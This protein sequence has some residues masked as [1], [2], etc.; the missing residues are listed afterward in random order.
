M[1]GFL[2][3]FI[4]LTT[5]KT[6]DRLPNL[7]PEW[8]SYADSLSKHENRPQ[9]TPYNIGHPKAKYSLF[10]FDP[11]HL[12][13]DSFCLLGFSQK[14]AQVIDRYRKA[15]G[16]F[17][18]ANDFSRLY[19][20]NDRH[21]VQ[22]KPFIR[23]SGTSKALA[24]TRRNS[25]VSSDPEISQASQTEFSGKVRLD[26]RDSLRLVYQLFQCELNSVDSTQL[27]LLPGVGPYTAHKILSYRKRL[28]GFVRVDQLL[29]AGLDH[30]L[31]ERFGDKV[32]VD[33]RLVKK[34]RLDSLHWAFLRSHPYVGTYLTRGFQ[35]YIRFHSYPRSWSELIDNQ[36]ITIEKVEKLK[37]YIDIP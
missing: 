13:V 1:I 36:I 20:V 18:D 10:I 16:F 19:V 25:V 34:V 17:R 11:N 8:M 30:A 27:L 22:L 29:E 26:K 37:Y 15:G 4:L 3:L 12:S 35:L 33:P 2:V 21:F 24:D 9:K 31:L 32:K 5:L 6:C 23:I 28:G 14:Q 7:R